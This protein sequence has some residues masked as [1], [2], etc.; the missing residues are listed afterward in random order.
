MLRKSTASSSA[1]E[2]PGIYTS[3]QWTKAVGYACPYAVLPPP[4]DRPQVVAQ[5]VLLVRV[6]GSLEKVGVSLQVAEPPKKSYLYQR[7]LEGNQYHLSSNWATV[8]M[9]KT[10]GAVIEAEKADISEV[11]QKGFCRWMLEKETRTCV[12][13]AKCASTPR[14]RKE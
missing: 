6:P 2:A 3:T 13:R 14:S 1:P 4:N 11:G 8:D 9:E 7:D 5:I 10:F 12:G